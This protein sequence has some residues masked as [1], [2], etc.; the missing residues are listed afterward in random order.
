MI[1]LQNKMLGVFFFGL[2]FGAKL[3]ATDAIVTITFKA[4]NGT[5]IEECGNLHMKTP[6]TGYASIDI[7]CHTSDYKQTITC[8]KRINNA[9]QGLY[10]I[11]G[12]ITARV[13]PDIDNPNSHA[14]IAADV[15]YTIDITYTNGQE[16]VTKQRSITASSSCRYENMV[17][18]SVK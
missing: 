18:F 15:P 5:Y 6:R 16:D 7:V 14:S 10:S 9:D 12:A 11:L 4:P 13:S 1:R 17:N 3:L 8:E 2:C